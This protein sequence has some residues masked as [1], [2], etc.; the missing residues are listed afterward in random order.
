MTSDVLILGGGLAGLATADALRDSGLR[1][2]ILEAAD[3]LGGRTWG[4]HWEPAG[5]HIDIGGTWLLPTFER[6][7]A[8]LKELQIDT[9]ESPDSDLWLTHFRHGPAVQRSLTDTEFD[10]LKRA[11]TLLDEIVAESTKPLT[12]EAALQ[13]VRARDHELSDLIEDWQ[14]AMQ[15]YLAGAPLTEVGVEHLTLN[16]DD[17]A[18]PEHYHT[19][20]AGTTDSLTRALVARSTADILLGEQVTSVASDGEEF[21][22][23]TERGNT[24]RARQVVC[25]IPMNC[26]SSVTFQDGIAGDAQRLIDAGHVGASRKDW[27]VL[28]NV[29][30]HFRVFA[31]EGPY[32]YFRSEA[33]LEDGGMLCVGLTPSADADPT[34]AELEEEIRKYYL[35]TATVRAHYCHDWV[36]DEHARGTWFVPRPGQYAALADLAALA[37]L[38]KNADRTAGTP[39]QPGLVFVGGDFDHEFPGTIE[40]AIGSGQRVA[41]NILGN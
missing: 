10:E 5:R 26:L 39:P 15:R 14:R 30:S 40:G 2:T 6:S 9:V 27:F 4:E 24:F 23:T 37:T 21:V 20:I 29:P 8:L 11:L 13:L 3:R 12:G 25:A 41:A 22:V 7:F 1:V 34:V 36:G 17:V 16:P 28:D 35:P 31:S 38:A 19:Q 18:D 32:G 33:R